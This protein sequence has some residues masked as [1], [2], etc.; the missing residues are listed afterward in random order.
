[1]LSTAVVLICDGSRKTCRALLGCGSQANFVSKKFVEVLSLE[2]RPLNVS[3][4]GVNGMVTSYNHVV[5]IKLQSRLNS[6]IAAIECNVTDQITNKIPAV[7]SERD[8]F[9]FPRNIRLADP[10]FHISSDIDLLIGAELFWN[11]ICVGQVKSSDKHPILQKTGL[12]FGGRLGSTISTASKVHASVTNAELYEHVSRAWQMDDIS[13]QPD[14]Y[15]MEENIC[16]R[17]F[18]DNVSQNSQ[19]RYTLKLPVREQML[20]NRR[21]A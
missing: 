16:E 5:R 12:D 8:K 11:L 20:N 4:S 17:H 6:Y 13:A 18:L 10:Q 19:S 15:T 7:S 14:N 2:T 9:K 1:M 21:F 3:I